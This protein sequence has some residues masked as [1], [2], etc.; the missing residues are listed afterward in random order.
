MKFDNIHVV[1][2]VIYDSQQQILLALR[3]SHQHQGGLWEFPG[4]KVESGETVAQALRRELFEELDIYVDN[5]RPLM[6][7]QHRY[8]DKDILLDVWQVIAWHGAARGKEGQ[9]LAWCDAAM[10]QSKTFP[11]ANYPILKA[12]QLPVFY[13]IT[14]EPD[15]PDDKHFFRHLEQRL[16][17]GTIQ[18]VQ[19]RA[20]RFSD[21]E[22]CQ[23]AERTMKLCENHAA[24]LLVNATPKI[25]LSV[26]THG[27]HLNNERLLNISQRPLPKNILVAASCHTASDIARADKIDS[28]FIVLSP[29]RPTPSHPGA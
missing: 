8:P 14:P 27:L 28:D 18:L 23:C 26:G 2:G 6:R 1:A 25:A 16:D 21:K 7:I 15:K 3:P 29:L 4:G 17:S 10:L 13:L 11:T 12:I 9:M 19:L 22:L 5:A 20:T 24:R